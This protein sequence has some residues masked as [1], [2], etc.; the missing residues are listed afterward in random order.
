MP[1][2]WSPAEA[3]KF[4]KQARRGVTY[5]TINKHARNLGA[6]EDSRTYSEHVFTRH[7]P[8]TGN[9]MT[10]GGTSAE[11]LCLRFGPVYDTPP[12]GLRNLDGPAPQVAGPLPNGY[13]AYLDEVELRGLDK[14]VAQGSNPRWRTGPGSRRP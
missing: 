13:E 8:L 4:A 3:K 14:Q 2:S 5:Y 6:Y 9:L 10:D 1:K 7:A 12:K 11:G